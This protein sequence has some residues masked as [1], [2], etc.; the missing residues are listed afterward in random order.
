MSTL[1]LSQIVAALPQDLRHSLRRAAIPR[2][3]SADIMHLIGFGP[4]RDLSS[5]PFV[6]Q[7]AWDTA[8]ATYLLDSGIRQALMSSEVPADELAQLNTALAEHFLAKGDTLNSLYHRL[9]VP[10]LRA[11]ALA[12]LRRE[13]EDALRDS[14]VSRAHDVLRVAK[15]HPLVTGGM[16]PMEL[17]RLIR[18][19]TPCIARRARWTREREATRRYY[20]RGF[21][22]ETWNLLTTGSQWILSLH[23]PGGFGKTMFLQNLIS[24]TCV[25]REI[26]VA[27]VDFD[28]VA[29]L[30]GTSSQPW[31]LLL[32]I[33][34]QL[35]DQMPNDPFQPLLGEWGH[36]ET[37]MMPRRPQDCSRIPP[38]DI[39][40][41]RAEKNVPERF[42]RILAE[43]K[44]P[45][46]VAL[47]TLENFLH[48]EGSTLC[49]VIDTLSK[50]H[51]AAP[52]L[53]LVLAGRFDLS[54]QVN[55]EDRVPGF[56][57]G[58]VG[59]QPQQVAI[60]NDATLVVGAE[61]LTLQVPS[62][63]P[64][65]A[66]HYLA[67][68]RGLDPHDARTEVIVA[69]AGGNPMKLSMLADIMRGD[70]PPSLDELRRLEDVELKYLV[71]RIIDRIPDPRVQWLLRWG[72]VP[73][74]LTREFASQVLWPM[75]IQH[76][77]GEQQWDEPSRDAL[78]K[79]GRFETRY[80]IGELA[81]D[82]DET[83]K[84]LTSYSAEASWISPVSE[85]PDT[86]RFHPEVRDP[87]RGLLRREQ[88]AIY[89]ECS[90]RSLTYWRERAETS[91]G[92]QRQRALCAVVFHALEP[93]EGRPDPAELFDELL[94]SAGHV[95]E[96]RIALA[97][98]VLDV[99]RR[100]VRDDR[101]RIPPPPPRMLARAHSVLAEGALHALLT[102][103]SRPDM[104][105][106]H[107]AGS[108]LS[109]AQRAAIEGRALLA[110]G[111]AGGAE[112]K[113]AAALS[114]AADLEPRTRLW[115]TI[116]LGELR[117][118]VRALASLVR[119]LEGT[120]EWHEAALA[121]ARLFERG[122]D[123]ED[124]Q[125]LYDRLGD[126]VGATRCL[127][128]LG[129]LE[130]AEQRISSVHAEEADLARADLCLAQLDPAGVLALARHAVRRRTDLGPSWDGLQARAAAML[131]HVER[132]HGLFEVAV[133]VRTPMALAD[134]LTA[135][136]VFL[137]SH[138]PE[139]ALDAL[140]ALAPSSPRIIITRAGLLKAEA[141]ARQGRLKRARVDLAALVFDGL[142]MSVRVDAEVLRL[143]LD[144]F[145]RRPPSAL[146][147]LVAQCPSPRRRLML[148][149][150]LS[151]I[152]TPLSHC[153]ALAHLSELT[154]LTFPAPPFLQ[155][156]RIEVLRL[157][158]QREAAHDALDSLVVHAL[159][160]ERA[161][162]M[163]RAALHAYD[164][165]Q[166]DA[167]A[168]EGK[169]RS[170]CRSLTD[171][172]LYEP[173]ID[174]IERE[175]KARHTGARPG[176]QGT[177]PYE[178]RTAAPPPSSTLIAA[179]QPGLHVIE[180]DEGPW[181]AAQPHRGF[182]WEH[183]DPWARWFD[184]L[185]RGPDSFFALGERLLRGVS[186]SVPR[187]IVVLLGDESR[188][189][190]PWEL[191]LAPSGN[192]LVRDLGLRCIRRASALAP[193]PA[194]V[195]ATE[196][197]QVRVVS[198]GDH[199]LALRRARS[200]SFARI[201]CRNSAH[202][203]DWSELVAD[204]FLIHVVGQFE[205]RRGDAVVLDLC[206]NA[207]HA[208]GSKHLARA[209]AGRGAPLLVILEVPWPGSDTEA[210]RQLVLRE[211]FAWQVLSEYEGANLLC[212]GFADHPHSEIDEF[213]AVPRWLLDERL[214]L[215]D[216]VGRLQAME[217]PTLS[218]AD[219]LS[220][221]GASLYSNAPSLRCSR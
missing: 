143:Q 19:L 185:N 62:F 153:L 121:L 80:T 89:H 65:D 135:A 21:D 26:P 43:W 73:Q 172:V 101:E 97:Q 195:L 167:S 137:D 16:P 42:S 116:H 27:R 45:V 61:I 217:H 3:L 189:W 114:S 5:M 32:L 41:A 192:S 44:K 77:A 211:R 20:P 99:E 202:W 51:T 18:D 53:R 169:V 84:K 87:I 221:T 157:S 30:V 115:A 81:L 207:S 15:E 179:P 1:D 86:Q 132:S 162:P 171:R 198:K 138:R 109:N 199:P 11:G 92:L 69:K 85:L 100:S 146:V 210:A 74:V 166:L 88:Q 96:L 4:E 154:E 160:H 205:E 175:Q 209:L 129:E 49:N 105:A 118:D 108:D 213:E 82:F 48:A 142:P 60:Q 98:E 95:L 59:A 212:I 219:L 106:H 190:V 155:L 214:M 76:I 7:A 90:K 136:R 183:A 215:A 133:R 141:E 6:E 131:G 122:E 149:R 52:E 152:R 46:V 203:H 201:D 151:R 181:F 180:P 91:T 78:G 56:R 216:L 140:R 8:G 196:K 38:P 94:A 28:Y 70:Q 165:L 113:L 127:V 17:E 123:L 79:L 33:A 55:G 188:A 173:L 186:R 193:S 64:E 25:E 176:L 187:E 220:R 107:L 23:A 12:A 110:V 102:G 83:W 68:S 71:D 9:Y 13:V 174:L 197:S 200:K 119:G 22:E 2:V 178:E 128:R 145:D 35:T 50:V 208:T 54:G 104:L 57:A 158:Y 126:A 182:E 58:Y 124:A 36:L 120:P 144:G 34:Q 159:Q 67:T 170:Y 37:R 134:A 161:L 204:T 39:E 63:S 194:S 40:D 191:A 111:D 206:T 29:H 130:L 164:R 66:R 148:M 112:R 14:N 117:D 150:G 139:D 184:L 163:L 10:R 125:R 31:R 75:L 177:G 168:A 147:E 24:R 156:V 93:F 72:T 47:D 218:F 103:E